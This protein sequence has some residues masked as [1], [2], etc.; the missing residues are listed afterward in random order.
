MRWGYPTK[1]RTRSLRFDDPNRVGS[2]GLAPVMR[3]AEGAGL[4]SSSLG[5]WGVSYPNAT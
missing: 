3:L 4:H 5:S 2:A 1:H